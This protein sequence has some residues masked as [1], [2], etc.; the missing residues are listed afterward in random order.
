MRGYRRL[1]YTNTASVLP[2]ATGMLER[3]MG[4]EVRITR[5]LLTASDATAR[6]W[7]AGNSARNWSRS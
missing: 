7:S 3:A 2:E 5:V 1:I 4:A 6:G